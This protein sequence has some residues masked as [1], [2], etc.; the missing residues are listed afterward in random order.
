MLATLHNQQ[1]R[2]VMRHILLMHGVNLNILGIR[3]SAHYGVLTLKDIE[4]ITT[5]EAE[6]YGFSI[7]P[8]QSNHEGDLIDKLQSEAQR[9]VGIVINPGAFTHY[10][11]GLHDALLDTKLPA[12]EVHLSDLS[13]RE[14]WRKHSVTAPACIRVIA[15]KQE[16]GYREAVNALVEYLQ[17]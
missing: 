6:K 9:C 7:T 1:G 14:P 16:Q 2:T 4:D 11:Y 12:I 10:S 5:K 17:K 15:G 13:L 3:D 8:Y